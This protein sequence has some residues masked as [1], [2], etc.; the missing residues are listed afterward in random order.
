MLLPAP[1]KGG[2]KGLIQSVIADLILESPD[3][4]L[5]RHRVRFQ[6]MYDSE[7]LRLSPTLDVVFA[8]RT[9][10]LHRRTSL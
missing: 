5:I 4:H 2:R 6:R 9:L 10:R 7:T 1:Q 8:Y 3:T